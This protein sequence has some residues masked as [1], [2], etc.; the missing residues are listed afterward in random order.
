M[1]TTTRRAVLAGAATLSA[2]AFPALAAATTDADLIAL[3]R[4]YEKLLLKYLDARLQWAPLLR[5]A[6]NEIREVTD[7]RQA[8]IDRVRADPSSPYPFDL[9]RAESGALNAAMQRN[10][11]EAVGDQMS[12]LSELMEPIAEAIPVSYTHLTLP[13]N[14]E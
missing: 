4:R 12:K 6:N 3:G 8:A 9:L 11:C 2:L 7:A 14:R 10:G 1:K 13:T 5:A